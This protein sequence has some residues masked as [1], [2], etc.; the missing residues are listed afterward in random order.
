MTRGNFLI[1]WGVYALALL[2]VWFAELF[3]LNRFPVLGVTPVLLPLAAAAVGVLEGPT[4]GGGYGM[5]VGVVCDAV[6]A[7]T[8][9]AM[10]VGVCALGMLSGVLAQYVLRRGL[11]GCLVCSALT[12]GVIDLFRVAVR[13]F[14]GT[15]GAAALLRVAGAELLWSMVFVF[16]VYG[17]YFWVFQRTPKR[18]VL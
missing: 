8:T 7:S 9:G 10:T 12:L 4:A 17:L 3:V 2:P 14:H 5:F 15:A 11:A 16:P 1:K 6:Y 13:L 18:T